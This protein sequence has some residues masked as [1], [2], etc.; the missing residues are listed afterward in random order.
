VR[1]DCTREVLRTCKKHAKKGRSIPLYYMGCHNTHSIQKQTVHCTCAGVLLHEGRCAIT[2]CDA[3]EGNVDSWAAGRWDPSGESVN[4]ES[5]Q[6]RQCMDLEHCLHW[7]HLEP[8]HL[9]YYTG[10]TWSPL[11]YCTIHWLHL[12]PTHLLYCTG[13]TWSPLTCC[14]TS[15]NRTYSPGAAQY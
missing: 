13:Y 7:L 4:S 15:I 8:T 11:T 6:V 5:E 14:T 10:Y 2:E 12:E 1:Y 9:L 3:S